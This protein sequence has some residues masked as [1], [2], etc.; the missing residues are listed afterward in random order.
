[1]ETLQ[2]TVRDTSTV[3]FQFG[4][5][6]SYRKGDIQDADAAKRVAAAIIKG[7]PEV[8]TSLYG[9]KTQYVRLQPKSETV[10][11]G[12]TLDGAKIDVPSSLGFGN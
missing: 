10:V 1:M 5:A 4:E 11:T 8:V 9:S 3:H 7:G 6:N 12:A 2:A